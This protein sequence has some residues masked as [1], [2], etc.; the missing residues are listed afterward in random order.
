MLP[1]HD[2]LALVANRSVDGEETKEHVKKFKL[3]EILKELMN[4]LDPK[5]KKRYKER[6]IKVQNANIISFIVQAPD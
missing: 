6:R 5:K 3:R 4:F 1:N 2:M